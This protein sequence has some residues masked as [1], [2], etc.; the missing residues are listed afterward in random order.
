MGDLRGEIPKDG[1]SNLLLNGWIKQGVDWAKW[2][3]VTLNTY[4]T[5]RYQMDTEGL[6]YNNLRRPRPRNISRGV[7]AEGESSPRSA[8]SISGTGISV[9]TKPR[10]STKPAQKVAIYVNWYGWWDLKK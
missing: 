10:S 2:G 3:N 5:L 8:S 4:A 9:S 7:L 6:D 1:D